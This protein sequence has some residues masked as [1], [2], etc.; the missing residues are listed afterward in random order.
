[1]LRRRS[2][3]SLTE[4]SVVIAVISILV[5]LLLPAVQKCREA[6][7]RI[8]CANNLKQLALSTHKF[9]SDHHR[10]PPLAGGWGSSRLTLIIGGR[11]R[12]FSSPTWGSAICTG[13]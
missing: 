8:Q 3:F 6:A 13:R 4:L 12:P 2:A 11:R 1:M 9:E 10:L 7:T 5:G